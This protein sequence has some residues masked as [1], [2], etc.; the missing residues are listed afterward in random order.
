MAS[1][2]ISVSLPEALVWKL[3]QL[4]SKKYEGLT[5]RSTLLAK[6]VLMLVSELNT[7]RFPGGEFERDFTLEE[8]EKE[9]AMREV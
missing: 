4:N 3:D 6:A 9:Y 7:R 5:T 1:K 8:I 2:V